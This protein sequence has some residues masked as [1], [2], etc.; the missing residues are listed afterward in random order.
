M[1]KEKELEIIRTD[2]PSDGSRLAGIRRKVFIEEQRVP[3]D[4]EWDADDLSACHFLA[5]DQAGAA[6]GTARLLADGRIGRMA[7]L[8]EARGRGI[9]AALLAAAEQEAAAQGLAEVYLSAQVQ[10]LPFYEKAGYRAYG[11]V[12]SDAGIDHLWMRKQLK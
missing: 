2:W 4:E 3:E 12:F 8:F 9:G 1:K 6:L 7:V 5:L 11:E 10:A